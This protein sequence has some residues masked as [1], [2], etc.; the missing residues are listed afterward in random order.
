MSDLLFYIDMLK[1][2]ECICGRPKKS[3]HTFCY[4]CYKAL[5]AEM[6]KDLYLP[7]GD[8]YEEAVDKACKYLHQEV[9]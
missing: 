5:P 2:E 6:Q 1:S 7:M 8:N 3:M 4:R 9:W